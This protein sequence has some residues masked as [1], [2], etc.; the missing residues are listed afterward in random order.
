MPLYWLC[1]R[2]NNQVQVVIEL[3]ASLMHARMQAALAGLD[4]GTFN[5]SLRKL[6]QLLRDLE[7]LVLGHDVLPDYI[8][9]NSGGLMKLPDL[10]GHFDRRSNSPREGCRHAQGAQ[11][12]ALP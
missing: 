5:I 6:A 4:Q 9:C 10:A 12:P 1:Y 3:G 2:H 8:I 11:L 7:G